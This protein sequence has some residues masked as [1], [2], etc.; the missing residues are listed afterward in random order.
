MSLSTEVMDRLFTRLSLIYGAAW[1]RSLGGAPIADIK[2]C[3]ADELAGFDSKDGLMA[4]SWALQ[5]LP[6]RCPNVLE[7]RA[8]V[9]RAPGPVLV[10]LQAPKADPV[11]VAAALERQLQV[12]AAMSSGL[13]NPKEWAKRLVARAEA[14]ERVRPI[15]LM[16]A[17]QALGT[18]GVAA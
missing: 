10:A 14:G 11:V 17:K 6:D 12:K 5:N 1:D 13:Y 3:W 9:R 18:T 2:T 16:F 8:L 7:F 15:A 4:V